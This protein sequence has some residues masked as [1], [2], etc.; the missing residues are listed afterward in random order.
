MTLRDTAY[1]WLICFTFR[2][3]SFFL[4]RRRPPRSTRTDTLFP[5]TTLFRSPFTRDRVVSAHAKS[6][7]VVIQ[8]DNQ[9]ITRRCAGHG[10]QPVCDGIA[11][12]PARLSL[13][14][15]NLNTTQRLRHGALTYTRIQRTEAAPRHAGS[16]QEQGKKELQN[17]TEERRG[18]KEG[19]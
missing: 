17:M 5:D 7:N 11:H 14:R 12:Q 10:R 15:R 6:L 8:P 1:L 18:R 9:P 13:T 19:E 3:S 4:T 2:L 16:N